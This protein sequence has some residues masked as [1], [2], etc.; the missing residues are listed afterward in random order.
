MFERVS[1]PV[2]VTPDDSGRPRVLTWRGGRYLVTDAIRLSDLFQ[3]T[4][5][6]PFD[7]YRVS[8]V[9]EHGWHYRLDLRLD[10]RNSS[11]ALIGVSSRSD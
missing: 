6:L 8:V 5:P 3:P 4:H 2:V 9:N 1:D 7:G 11:W 10:A